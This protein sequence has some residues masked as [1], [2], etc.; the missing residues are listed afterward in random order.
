MSETKFLISMPLLK[1][2]KEKRQVVGYA[3]TEDIDKQN[4][5]VDFEASKEAFGSWAGNIREMHEPKAVGKAVAWEPDEDR[6]GIRVTAQISKGAEDTWQKILDGTLKAFSIGG[7]TVNKVQ[8]IV[9]DDK[10]GQKHVTKIT[11][12]RLTELSLVDNPAN[13]EASFELVKFADGV[14]MQTEIVEDMKKVLI[15]Q[16][17]DILEAE[18]K[19]HRNKADALA[20]KVLTNEELD[21]LDS[22]NWG[23]IRKFEKEGTKYIERLLPMPDK[24]HAVRALAVIDNYALTKEEQ[25][26]VHEI[27]KSVLGSDYETYALKTSRGGEIK[28]MN[29]EILDTLKSLGEQLADLTKKVLSMEKANMAAPAKSPVTQEEV[30]AGAPDNSAPEKTGNFEADGVTPKLKEATPAHPTLKTQEEGNVA[31]VKKADE[32]VPATE[33]AVE[34]DEFGKPKKK[35]ITEAE[36]KETA[37]VEKA[38]NPATSSIETQ[39]APAVPAVEKAA[40]PA[41]SSLKTQETP[42]VPAPAKAVKKSLDS[43][44]GEKVT[45]ATNQLLLAEIKSLRKRLDAI[46]VTPKPRKFKVEKNF[47]N[48]TQ[49]D[50]SEGLAEA[51]QK[52]IDLRK[53]ESNGRKLTAEELSYIQKTLDTSLGVKFNKSL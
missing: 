39:E 32:A 18:V 53:Q 6:R 16:S 49:A 37:P 31:P 1:V 21:S 24:V 48:E 13:P 45:E 42:A 30:T 15:S 40:N 41:T 17:E 29:N 2:D 38:K 5:Q 28:K 9:K 12:Y 50:A 44:D 14:P 19:D 8:Q 34:L 3:T 36:V 23:V 20:K 22:E 26:R 7:Q 52:C 25:D 43:V 47:G 11:K 33:E 10:G 51:M 4:E 46:D 35:K 27:A